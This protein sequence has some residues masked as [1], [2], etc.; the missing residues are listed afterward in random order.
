MKTF[1][2][3]FAYS[4]IF[5]LF[6]I[7]VPIFANAISYD[8]ELTE[9]YAYA[10][11]KWIT[12]MSNINSANM[13]GSLTRIAMAKMVANYVLDLKLQERDTSKQCT[14]SDVPA[15]LDLAYGNGVTKACQLG[16]MGVGITDFN[17]N[18]IVT[19]AEFGTVL[20]RAL[21]GDE[22]NGG[23][24]Y[25]K[26]HLQALKDNR[27]MIQTNDP[28]RREVRGYVMLMMMRADEKYSS[29]VATGCTA[30][31]LLTCLLST[32]DYQKCIANC[33]GD[34][35]PVLSGK[36]VISRL[37]SAGLQTIPGNA[38]NVNVGT[39]KITA[40]NNKVKVNSLTFKANNITGDIDSLDNIYVANDRILSSVQSFNPST[41]EARLTFSPALIL[42]AGK[43]ETLNVYV[44]MAPR[45]DTPPDSRYSFSISN[46]VA[47]SPKSGIPLDLGTIKTSSDLVS[48]V[49]YSVVAGSTSNQIAWK[50]NQSIVKVQLKLGNTG[51]IIKKVILTKSTAENQNFT[52]EA[53]YD[54]F[55]NIKA[56]HSGN[57]VATVGI[58]ENDLIISNLNISGDANEI[59]ELELKWDIIYA[60]KK[61]SGAFVVD[62]NGTNIIDG[63][64]RYGA[65]VKAGYEYVSNPFDV[66]GLDLEIKNAMTGN[67]TVSPGDNDVV[68]YKATITSA[69][70]LDVLE[71]ILDAGVNIDT[72]GGFKLNRIE[73]YVNDSSEYINIAEFTGDTTPKFYQGNDKFFLYADQPVTIKV[74]GSFAST[75]KPQDFT[76]TFGITKVK[77]L[78]NNGT[79]VGSP[80]IKRATWKTISVK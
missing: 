79:I 17:P 48:E 60:G 64:S 23:E 4:A 7:V 14:F 26:K 63:P 49:E 43:S 42:S 28:G 75:A 68:L 15:S 32:G 50:T 27:I 25:Y 55:A 18:G 24:P 76:F 19:R 78:L 66:D 70:D 46:L 40:E 80:T 59:I 35:T 45:D 29:V 39:I 11:S 30:E 62:V 9:A 38:Q 6:A 16:L 22:N 12:T 47:D 44:N 74:L 67:L 20:S 73:L 41:K 53:F 72:Y 33:S 3:L 69:V 54:I 58:A 37:D 65:V 10:K 8:T 61:T 57:R 56:Y 13:Y 31:E 52:W 21:W 1:K 36:V 5:A 71:Y 51:A 77:D 34:T 2:K